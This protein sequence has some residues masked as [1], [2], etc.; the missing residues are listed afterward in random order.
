MQS[1]PPVPP[2]SRLERASLISR[3]TEDFGHFYQY[4]ETILKPD[5]TG[6]RREPRRGKQ[7][8]FHIS[9]RVSLSTRRPYIYSLLSCLVFTTCCSFITTRC[10]PQYRLGC[11]FMRGGVKWYYFTSI[12]ILPSIDTSYDDFTVEVYVYQCIEIFH[13]YMFLLAMYPI[14]T[15]EILNLEI[16]A[17][18][19]DVVDTVSKVRSGCERNTSRPPSI[20]FEVLPIYAPLSSLSL[21]PRTAFTRT[22]LILYSHLGS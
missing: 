11:I 2:I 19:E 7:Q 6:L 9:I 18:F 12:A 15:L 4:P 8:L 17:G 10:S 1:S 14:Q 5:T 21:Y 13:P 22:L 16:T 20:T 3:Y